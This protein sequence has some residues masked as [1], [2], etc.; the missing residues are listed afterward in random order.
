MLGTPWSHGFPVLAELCEDNARD[1]EEQP[2]T[3]N[4]ECAAPDPPRRGGAFTVLCGWLLFVIPGIVFAKLSEH[5]EAVTPRS[6]QHL[7]AIS[8]NLVQVLAGLCVVAVLLG[9]TSVL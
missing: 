5:W 9:M 3:E 8:F 2:T 6:S 7:P 4:R 1:D